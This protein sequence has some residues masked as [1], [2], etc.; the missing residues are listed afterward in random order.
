[1]RSSVPGPEYGASEQA[2]RDRYY[3]LPENRIHRVK[4]S[5]FFRDNYEKDLQLIICLAP[6]MI[7]ALVSINQFNFCH[8]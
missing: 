7:S 4:F 2:S 3:G 6:Q 1:M 8:D 5:L